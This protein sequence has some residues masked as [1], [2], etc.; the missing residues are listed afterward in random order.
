VPRQPAGLEVSHRA[1]AMLRAVAA[2]RAQISRGS[3]PDLFVDGLPCCDQAAAR[4]L[5][6]AGLVCPERLGPAGDRVPAALT[7]AGFLLLA[8]RPDVA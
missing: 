2:G 5:V 7:P 8:S 1:L 6:H 4:A 3:E